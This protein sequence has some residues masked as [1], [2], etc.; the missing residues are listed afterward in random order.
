MGKILNFM[1]HFQHKNLL[2]SLLALIYIKFKPIYVFGTG[3]VDKYFRFKLHLVK[4][5]SLI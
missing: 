3:I 2:K 4:T 5:P 1:T